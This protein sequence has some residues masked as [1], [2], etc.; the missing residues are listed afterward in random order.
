MNT[1]I[2][3]ELN[4]L[5]ESYFSNKE[6]VKLWFRNHKLLGLGAMNPKLKKQEDVLNVK[7]YIMYMLP[8]KWAGAGNTCQHAT[9]ACI[10]SC[11]V[12]SGLGAFDLKVLAAR[13]R[14]TLFYF[15][16]PEE[17]DAQLRKELDA[18]EQKQATSSKQYCIRLNGGS[19]LDY[20]ATYEQYPTLTFW[21]YTKDF[22][23]AMEYLT[24]PNF[25]TNVHL[26]FSASE[27]S[28]DEQLLAVLNAGGRVAMVMDSTPTSNTNFKWHGFPVENG[29]THDFFFLRPQGIVL[30][31]YPKGTNARK[32][33]RQGFV[34]RALP[35]VA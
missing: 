10:F 13:L 32:K 31:L 20:L 19:D 12:W 16:F 21:E 29:D 9:P 6:I 1:R 30:A 14:K 11:L 35:M 18:L 7:S 27:K 22:N 24:D 15:W 2:R 17:F 33:E 25:P 8:H 23:R 26:A 5:K 3:T 28:T 34:R 4:R